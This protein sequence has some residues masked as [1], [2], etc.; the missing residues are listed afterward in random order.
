MKTIGGNS[1]FVRC[2]ETMSFYK[3]V[4]VIKPKSDVLGAFL[5][6]QSQFERKHNCKVKT[7]VRRQRWRISCASGQL[8]SAWHR[9][10]LQ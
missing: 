10:G 8:V 7:S 3:T 6:V 1:Y 9:V 5:S 2:T 4:K